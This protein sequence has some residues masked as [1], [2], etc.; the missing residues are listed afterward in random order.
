MKLKIL[1]WF[2]R[3][4]RRDDAAPISLR[5]WSA[6]RTDRLNEDAW[7]HAN[8]R[9]IN[10]DLADFGETVRARCELEVSR[11]TDVEGVIHTHATDVIGESGPILQVKTAASAYESALEELWR[12]WWSKPDINGV[13]AGVDMLEQW[14]RS[15]WTTGEYLAQIVTDQQGDGPVKA[16]LHSLSARRLATS[17]ARAGDA[18]VVLG[19]RR[20]KTGQPISYS[21]DVSGDDALTPDYKE[22]SAKDIVHVFRVLEAGQVRGVPWLATG[23]QEISDL[24]EFDDQVM[25]AAR[26]AADNAVLLKTNHPDSNYVAVNE[27]VDIE[28]RTIS[29]CP[30]GWEPFQLTPQQPSAQ[31]LDF[32]DEKLRAI[33]RP[34]GM[35]LMLIKL[36]SRKHNYSSAR[37]DGQ[38]YWRGNRRL[39]RWIERTTLNRLVDLVSRE[40][41]LAKS[42]PPRPADVRY[43]WNWPAPPH[44]DPSK[45]AV[46]A[47]KRLTSW[48]STYRDECADRGLDWKDIFD[49][50]AA[51]QEYREQL[52]LPPVGVKAAAVPPAPEEDVP[53]DEKDEEDDDDQKR[54]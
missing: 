43:Q 29:T 2:K 52:G 50:Q 27:S 6:A 20:T 30:P 41:E 5:R 39:Q 46:G 25:D 51:E 49:Q 32:H 10:L 4:L 54:K 42:L 53:D 8:G 31:Y 13:L 11:N 44:V 24:R 14:W 23:L 22:I 33:G 9:H 21:I 18:D 40:A 48:T 37:F 19:V 47:E 35:P 3:N 17:P 26:Q 34:I 1:N 7:N 36:D 12:N 15:L 45:E 28:R 16:R 38:L